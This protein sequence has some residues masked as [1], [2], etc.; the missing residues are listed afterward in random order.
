MCLH[1]F[2]EKVHRVGSRSY[3]LLYQCVDQHDRCDL[4]LAL[5]HVNE[6]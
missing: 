6:L 4:W 3:N 2:N 5:W 1:I